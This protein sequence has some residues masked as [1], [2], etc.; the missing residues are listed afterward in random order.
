MFRCVNF[1][2]NPGGGIESGCKPI[3]TFRYVDNFSKKN[4]NLQGQEEM[5]VLVNHLIVHG[6]FHVT[7][8]FF[9]DDQLSLSQLFEVMGDGRLRKVYNFVNI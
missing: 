7:A 3:E 1:K 6:I 8:F 9:S 4:L 2:K 5:Y